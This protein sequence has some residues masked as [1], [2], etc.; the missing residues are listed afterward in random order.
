MYPDSTLSS[1]YLKATDRWGQVTTI[2]PATTYNNSHWLSPFYRG[3]GYIEDFNYNKV[4][5]PT[6]LTNY[7]ST[8]GFAWSYKINDV[9]TDAS[10]TILIDIPENYTYIY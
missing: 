8:D 1:F 10:K 2:Y 5:I 3:T 9:T 4:L 6:T 7:I